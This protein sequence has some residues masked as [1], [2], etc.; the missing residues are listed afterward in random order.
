VAGIAP[1][2]TAVRNK[3]AG[4]G[5]GRGAASAHTTGRGRS[6]GPRPTA[7]RPAAP[8][9]Q[10][11]PDARRGPG[12]WTA[13]PVRA[14]YGP[15]RARSLPAPAP[16]S[17]GSRRA[18]HPGAPRPRWRADPTP[19]R[20]WSAGR[21]AP[22]MRAGCTREPGGGAAGA[23]EG[24]QT[25]PGPGDRA[26]A[27]CSAGSTAGA[28]A[29]AAPKPRSSRF[30]CCLSEEISRV[31]LGRTS[32]LC[33]LRPAP[34][35]LS[36]CCPRSGEWRPWAGRRSASSLQQPPRRGVRP[37]SLVWVCPV[38]SSWILSNKSPRLFEPQFL[39]L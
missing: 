2:R 11:E 28:R 21:P 34:G 14:P 13:A 7:P 8:A 1:S 27:W 39:R 31:P 36:R 22:G 5:A 18:D 9:P 23:R 25:P 4:S 32:G 29:A 24:R 16:R 26:P 30:A 3:A 33:P 35:P 37:P 19:R 12:P 10:P 6:P 38:S 15:T 20:P 17:S